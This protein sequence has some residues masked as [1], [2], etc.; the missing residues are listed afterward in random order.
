M[1]KGTTTIIQAQEWWI[2]IPFTFEGQLALLIQ[3]NGF[4]WYPKDPI[5]EN[6]KQNKQKDLS[7]LIWRLTK[8]KFKGS[9]ETKLW[10]NNNNNN[11][12]PIFKCPQKTKDTSILCTSLNPRL[13]KKKIPII[14]E[15]LEDKAWTL[16]SLTV[17][18]ILVLQVSGTQGL[19]SSY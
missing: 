9:T 2:P 4:W 15:T 1:G 19:L 12:K 14:L 16:D 11:K 5:W 17:D 13:T 7:V 18:K 8:K 3:G 6:P 10:A